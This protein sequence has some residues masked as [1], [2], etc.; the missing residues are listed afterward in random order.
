MH[1]LHRPPYTDMPCPFFFAGFFQKLSPFRKPYDHYVAIC[2]HWCIWSSWSPTSVS[3]FYSPCYLALSI[4]PAPQSNGFAA[5]LH[6]TDFSHFFGYVDE[7][8]KLA[9]SHTLINN[10]LI[11][12]MFS[13]IGGVPLT[14]II[15]SYTQRVSFVLRI[16]FSGK[17][18]KAFCF[19]WSH[20]SVVS[21]SYGT[22]F[23]DNI[24]HCVSQKIAVYNDVHM[25][26][27]VTNSFIYSLK[28][29]DIKGTLRKL[30]CDGVIYPEPG[31]L[32][33]WHKPWERQNCL[34]LLSGSSFFLYQ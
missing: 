26:F 2:S 25:V 19:C 20:L 15:F 6:K 27:Q 11:Y 16:P 7:V 29:R 10:I 12:F 34:N 23:G 32:N 24:S 30:S 28:N 18:H 8:I 31:S 5:A 4:C 22:V 21:L 3:W 1:Q 14:G 13:L 33:D 17:K 9:S